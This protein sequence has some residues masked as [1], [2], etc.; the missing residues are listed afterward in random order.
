[1]YK[2]FLQ[3]TEREQ[4]LPSCLDVVR[5]ISIT[6]PAAH[7]TNKYGLGIVVDRLLPHSTTKNAHILVPGPVNIIW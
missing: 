6:R 4:T 3:R 2:I 5:T 1:M 7:C